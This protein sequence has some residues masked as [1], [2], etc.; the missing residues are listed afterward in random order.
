MLS[1]QY[2]TLVSRNSRDCMGG[3]SRWCLRG[4]ATL[5]QK[6]KRLALKSIN[7]VKYLVFIIFP[8]AHYFMFVVVHILICSLTHHLSQLI[9]GYNQLL[10]FCFNF[11][12]FHFKL[13]FKQQFFFSQVWELT[14]MGLFYSFKL[15]TFTGKDYQKPYWYPEQN[16]GNDLTTANRV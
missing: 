16:L 12:F 9:M 1:G 6:R 5:L 15:C 4:G 11:H 7:F 13:V 14:V 2:H 10:S 8:F 3:L